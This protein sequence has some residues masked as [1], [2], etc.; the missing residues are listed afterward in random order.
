[1]TTPN[2]YASAVAH[3]ITGRAMEYRQLITDPATHAEWQLLTANKF[4]RLVQGVGGRVKG[5]NTITFTPHNE[6]PNDR[7]A[8]YLRFV[9]SKRPQKQEKNQT[10]M[11]VGGNLID[12]PGNKSMQMAEL[13]TTKLLFNSM[14]STPDVRFCTMDITNFYLNTPL[15]WPEYLHIPW[16]L[17]PDEIMQEYNLHALVKNGNVLARIDKGMYGLPQ[18]GILANK[19]LKARLEPHGYCECNHTIVAAPHVGTHVLSTCG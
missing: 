19:L 11:T 1:M 9:C 10:R 5:T 14:I 15:D 8:T 6:M 16:N 7:Q 17:I 2:F 3:P 13:E 4:G 18:A 12:Y